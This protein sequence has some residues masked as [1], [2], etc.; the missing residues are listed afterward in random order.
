MVVCKL[1]WRLGPCWF[2]V[3]NLG[4]IFFILT[5]W[6]TRSF[7]FHFVCFLSMFIIPFFKVI[8]ELRY[9]CFNAFY[10]VT[11]LHYNSILWEELLRNKKNSYVG[12]L[13]TLT[14]ALSLFVSLSLFR[15]TRT[16][17][18][19]RSYFTP[20]V[21][22]IFIYKLYFAYRKQGLRFIYYYY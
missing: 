11:V 22:D 8:S 12:G 3:P 14:P 4:E 9:F 13:C 1:V 10:N 6:R 5:S 2:L 16:K 7:L 20:K 19:L 21:K 17:Y 18:I 15:G